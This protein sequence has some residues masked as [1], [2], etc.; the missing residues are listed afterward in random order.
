MNEKRCGTCRHSEEPIDFMSVDYGSQIRCD[1]DYPKYAWMHTHS[2]ACDRW[3][4]K[5]DQS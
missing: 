2:M 4:P 5:D 3:E 1:V